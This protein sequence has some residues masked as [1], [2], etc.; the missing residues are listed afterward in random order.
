ML[1]DTEKTGEWEKQNPLLC[2]IRVLF[3]C[4]GVLHRKGWRGE[5]EGVKLLGVC[6]WNISCRCVDRRMPA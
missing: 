1:P 6:L 4:I 2:F 3:Y 5:G